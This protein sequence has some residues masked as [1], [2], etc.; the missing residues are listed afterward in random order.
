MIQF[1]NCH[2]LANTNPYT[3]N[4]TPIQQAADRITEVLL[5]AKVD[6]GLIGSVLKELVDTLPA[7]KQFAEDAFKAGLHWDDHP[8]F[9]TYY[10]RYE[11]TNE[12]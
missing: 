4:K 9:P 10:S 12:G 7:E 8:D 11:T 2:T 3:M 5:K 1:Q 6:T